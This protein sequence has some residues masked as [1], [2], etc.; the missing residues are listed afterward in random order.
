[1]CLPAPANAGPRRRRLLLRL[2]VVASTVG[3][4][5]VLGTILAADGFPPLELAILVPVVA[6]FAWLTTSR[7]IPVLGFLVGLLDRLR[8]PRPQHAAN[9]L[10]GTRPS[11]HATC[12]ATR[13]HQHKPLAG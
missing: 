1:M 12:M 3:A 11:T 13:T 9:L 10:T 7:G 6:L 8:T 4:V 2:L 5:V